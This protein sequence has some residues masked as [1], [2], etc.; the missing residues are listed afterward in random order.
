MYAPGR[1]TK[2]AVFVAAERLFARD[3]FERTTVRAIAGEADVPVG[4]LYQFYDNK[5]ALFDAVVTDYLQALD[6]VFNAATD[7]VVDAQPIVPTPEPGPVVTG[8]VATIVEGITALASTRPAFRSMF[9]GSAVSGPFADAAALI[10]TRARDH[11]ARILDITDHG[12][13]RSARNRTAT[14]CVDVIRG[15]L[16]TAVDTSG[17]VDADISAE[18]ERLLALYVFH[19]KRPS[20]ETST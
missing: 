19:T 9:I 8:T 12:L 10:R 5:Q 2:H 13:G 11:T 1:A 4:S 7:K 6:D 17:H 16:G 3:G 20:L 18:L 15:L 14:V